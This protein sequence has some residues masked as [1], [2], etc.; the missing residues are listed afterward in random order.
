MSI[1]YQ[2]SGMRVSGSW[3]IITNARYLM[4]W[5]LIAKAN[6]KRAA[7]LNSPFKNRFNKYYWITSLYLMSVFSPVTRILATGGIFWY[8]IFRLS[9]ESEYVP[10]VHTIIIH[11]T[12]GKLFCISGI[13]YIYLL[14]DLEKPLLL[15]F[16]FFGLLPPAVSGCNGCPEEDCMRRYHL[17]VYL[18]I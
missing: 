10:S 11:K 2:L 6:S 16:F 7:R 3:S 17:W 12:H 15:L 4:P 5:C 9:P 1:R 14:P 13:K 18:G 8:I